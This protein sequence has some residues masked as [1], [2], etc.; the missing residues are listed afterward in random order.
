MPRSGRDPP[1]DSREGLWRISHYFLIERGEEPPQAVLL[2]V[3]CAARTS[4]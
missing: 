2:P 3:C 1:V 4:M